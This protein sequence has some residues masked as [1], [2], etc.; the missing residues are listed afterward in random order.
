MAQERTCL[1]DLKAKEESLQAQLDKAITDH[2]HMCTT[3][4][5]ELQESAKCCEEMMAQHDDAK[6]QWSALEAELIGMEGHLQTVLD[7]RDRLEEKSTNLE[8]NIQ[9]AFSMQRYLESQLKDR[10]AKSSI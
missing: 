2:V 7:E 9:C 6:A 4:K 5:M 8:S 3:F 10:L 1:W